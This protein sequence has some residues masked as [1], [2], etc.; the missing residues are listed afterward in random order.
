MSLDPSAALGVSA[1]PLTARRAA[2]VFIFI[3]VALDILALGVMIPVLPKLVL[4]FLGGDSAGAAN[5]YGWFA[6]AFAGMQFLCSPLLGALSDRFGRRPV[7]LLSNLGLG[8][9]YIVMAL[10]PNLWVLFVGRVFAGMTSA[11]ISTANAY[12]ADVTPAEKRAAAFGMLG[13]AFGLGFVIGPALG[14]LLGSVDQ[15]LPFWVA[16]GLSLLNFAYGFFILPES[17]PPERRAP[18]AWRGANPLGALRFLRAH[19]GVAPL[20][21]IGFLSQLAHMSL[22]AIFVLY[23]DYRYGWDEW[24]VG[25][26]LAA[27]GVSSALVQG[28][29]VRRLVPRFGEVRMLRV[30]LLAGALGFL[31]YGFAPNA[32]WIW[33]AIPVMASWG[34]ATPS[35]QGLLSRRVDASEQGRLQ[36]ALTSLTGMAGIFGPF[37]FT[38]AFAAA[39]RHPLDWHLPGLAFYLAASLLAAALLLAFRHAR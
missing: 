7:V 26:A 30:G 27:V 17:L 16:A 34:F 11:S 38:Q 3:T 13:A 18:F 20:A 10:A 39:I 25:I 9:D 19:A 15:R 23:A 22:P 24:Q 35:M 5:W 8:L 1:A 37:L 6:A 28:G 36:G 32:A 21:L 2:V 33:L 29:L 14:G 4:G 31:L 12:I